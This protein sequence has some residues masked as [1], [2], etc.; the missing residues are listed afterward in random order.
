M[1]EFSIVSPEFKRT[2]IKPSIAT[3]MIDNISQPLSIPRNVMAAF[4]WSESVFRKIFKGDMN[5]IVLGGDTALAMHWD[6]RVSTDLDYFLIEPDILKAK[7][8]ISK[9][10]QPLRDLHAEGKIKDLNESAFHTRF[11]VQDTEITLFTTQS[12]IRDSA[13]HHEKHSELKLENIA[14]I[15][16][17]KINGR[18]LSL[19]DF[20][21]R[22]F[23]DFCIACHKEP[24]TFNKA[25]ST[26]DES[27]LE[28]IAHELKR[29][30]SSDLVNEAIKGKQL[31]EPRYHKIADN[32]WSH[33]ETVIRTRTIPD[34]L[35]ETSNEKFGPER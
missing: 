12:I 35:F 19:G 11:F 24:A 3:K 1:P 9:T 30:R 26:A 29:W 21:M 20:T 25:L 18:I 23:Y 6:H 17:K 5:K 28:S 16:A 27:D 15:L 10:K 13:T 22:D 8:L 7:E 2:I 4:Y 33:A 34:Y 31:I 32:L 14:E